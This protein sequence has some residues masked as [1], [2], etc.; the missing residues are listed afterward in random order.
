MLSFTTC[1]GLAPWARTPGAC[2]A[3]ASP[4]AVERTEAANTGCFMS[5]PLAGSRSETVGGST[6]RSEGYRWFEEI[7]FYR[8]T[9]GWC[10]RRTRNDRAELTIGQP[11]AG[12]TRSGQ[13][14]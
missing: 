10:M 12:Q 4:T 9:A 5:K 6:Q 3:S 1:G 7:H 14:V 8:R 13:D 11:G 2:A